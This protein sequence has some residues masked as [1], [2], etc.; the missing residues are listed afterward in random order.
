[1]AS[2]SSLSPLTL[3][4]LNDIISTH[5]QWEK[6]GGHEGQKAE[7]SDANLEGLDLSG[8][9]LSG[10]D[11][12]GAILAQVK[13]G[14]A[15]V[16][17]ASFRAADLR[18]ADLSAVRALLPL[19]LA[20]ADLAGAKL[21]ESFREF[22]ASK[23]VDAASSHVQKMLF[24]LLLICVYCWLTIAVTTDAGLL[25]NFSETPLPI[26]NTKIN[27]VMFYWTAPFLLLCVYLYLHICLQR[28]WEA[29]AEL[30]A[31]FPD[32]LP[33]PQHVHPW[34]WNGLV[35]AF[36]PRLRDRAPPVLKLQKILAIFLVWWAGPITILALWFRYLPAHDWTITTFQIVLLAFALHGALRFSLL[37]RATLLL[38][39]KRPALGKRYWRLSKGHA[40]RLITII[41]AL[42]FLFLSW[43][44]I[45]D[46][47]FIRAYKEERILNLFKGDGN[48]IG[49][50]SVSA[51]LTEAEVSWK[52]P[53]WTGDMSQVRGAYLRKRN[54]RG[55]WAN[56]AFLARADFRGADLRYANLFRANLRNADLS[57]PSDVSLMIGYCEGRARLEQANLQEADL[58]QANLYGACLFQ[59]NLQGADLQQANLQRA[60]LQQAY[61][62]WANLEETD[63]YG[64]KLEGAVLSET[65]LQGALRLEP[66][67]VRTA[68]CWRLAKYSPGMLKSLQL[69]VDHNHRM[70]ARDLSKYSLTGADLRYGDL[71]RFDLQDVDLK[72]ANLEQANMSEANLT[73]ADLHD[74]ALQQADLSSANLQQAKLV[75]ADLQF[76]RLS[77]ANLLQADLRAGNLRQADLREANLQQANLEKA[78]LQHANLDKANLAQAKLEGANLQGVGL[79]AAYLQGTDFKEA[80][81]IET[82]QVLAAACWPLAEYSPEILESLGLPPRHNKNLTGKNLS[83][84]QLPRTNLNYADL[85]EFKLVGANL[86]HATLLGA[87]LT[88]ADLRKANLKG[89]QFWYQYPIRTIVRVQP[90]PQEV[91]RFPTPPGAILKGA[92]LRGAKGLSREQLHYAIMDE[93][94]KL[95]D[96]LKDGFQDDSR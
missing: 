4:E 33:L 35:W 64:A 71:R 38:K 52:P 22:A 93:N 58:Q 80:K 20:G 90:F 48:F 9:D 83:G 54:L 8:Y 69:P 88:G 78:D 92:D 12:R 77:E 91:Y 72:G 95:P 74:A 6:S 26:I 32:G 65:N 45:E 87:D 30:P 16:E 61:L 17:R 66:S 19:Q 59:A 11:F 62:S 75:R 39:D 79:E 37:T 28:L 73:K 31:V 36:F 56:G 50:P 60:E 49:L 2:K 1:M 82:R 57:A 43:S 68:I 46:G 84:Y 89:A 40:L 14:E 70:D 94:T 13:F 44:A 76:A 63:L 15:L 23:Y 7:L 96:D 41:T 3:E 10:L 25:N 81:G 53:Q 85:R 21:P 86:E 55:A 29:L 24:L 18:E 27:L 67:Q 5:R 34:L 47:E 42:S 51:N